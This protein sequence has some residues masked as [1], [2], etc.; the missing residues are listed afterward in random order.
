MATF[1][2]VET[3]DVQINKMFDP[4]FAAAFLRS[5]AYVPRFGLELTVRDGEGKTLGI[6]ICKNAVEAAKIYHL[7][8]P[9][10]AEKFGGSEH[11]FR[12]MVQ[13]KYPQ[14]KFGLPNVVK[15]VRLKYIE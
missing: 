8:Y 15:L 9:E 3:R 13:G 1:V 10:V 7:T 4:I 2:P 6:H 5:R 14:P 11:S 12:L